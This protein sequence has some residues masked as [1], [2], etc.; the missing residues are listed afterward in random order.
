LTFAKK[1]IYYIFEIDKN[2]CRMDKLD[3]IKGETYENE[4][5]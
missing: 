4:N 5:A 1:V 3:L 2:D